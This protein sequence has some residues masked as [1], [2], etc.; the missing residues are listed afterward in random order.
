MIFLM[1]VRRL[2]FAGCNI[3]CSCQSV[4]RKNDVM[5]VNKRMVGLRLL[6][7][8]RILL[9]SLNMFSMSHLFMYIANSCRPVLVSMLVAK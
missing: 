5:A 3:F 7:G 4:N 9:A 1:N 6:V 8:N 2:F